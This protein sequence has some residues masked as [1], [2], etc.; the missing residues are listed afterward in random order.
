ML[1]H[2]R[3]EIARVHTPQ[4]AAFGTIAT[5]VNARACIVVRRTVHVGCLPD[6]A[7]SALCTSVHRLLCLCAQVIVS[8]V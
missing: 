8:A 6:A 5:T 3:Y 1:Q 2:M 4:Y 7:V